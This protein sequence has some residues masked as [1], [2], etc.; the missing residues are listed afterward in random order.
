MALE[1]LDG[2]GARLPVSGLFGLFIV[3]SGNVEQLRLGREPNGNAAPL[4]SWDDL[5]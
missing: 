5:E 4:W 3:V 1:Q 2:L